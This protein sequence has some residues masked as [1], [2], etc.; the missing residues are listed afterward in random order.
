[1]NDDNDSGEDRDDNDDD[2]DEDCVPSEDEEAEDTIQS[3]SWPLK[4][5][6][7]DMREILD[8]DL[9]TFEAMLK[10]P[11]NHTYTVND[12]NEPETFLRAIK[13]LYNARMGRVGSVGRTSLHLKYDQLHESVVASIGKKMKL[14][15]NDI[16][17]LHLMLQKRERYVILIET[18]FEF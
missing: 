17:A 18:I 14:D 15:E 12:L 3:P 16:A 7:D 4:R 5:R 11:Y 6:M 8:P 10:L 13:L 2:D 9:S 1:V